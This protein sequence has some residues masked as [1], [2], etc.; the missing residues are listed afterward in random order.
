MSMVSISPS[1]EEPVQQDLPSPGV[2]EDFRLHRRLYKSR[3][4][5]GLDF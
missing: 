5:Y 2:G 1:P 3:E 4:K